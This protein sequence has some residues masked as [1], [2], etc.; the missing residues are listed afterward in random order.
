M[1]IG[2]TPPLVWI[3]AVYATPT[4]P[5]GRDVV[6]IFKTPT[7]VRLNGCCADSGPAAPTEESVTFTVMVEVPPVVGVP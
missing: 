5:V 4:V 6:V 7:T 2:R 3:M 1:E